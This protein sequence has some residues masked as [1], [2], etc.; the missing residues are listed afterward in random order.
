[1]LWEVQAE[2]HTEVSIDAQCCIG[3]SVLGGR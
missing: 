1:M 3:E 2:V